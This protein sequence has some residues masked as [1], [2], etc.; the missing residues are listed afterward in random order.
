MVLNYSERD[1]PAFLKIDK[2]QAQY[3]VS[4]GSRLF[5]KEIPTVVQENNINKS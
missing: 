3:D 4:R 1:I 2:P 5:S